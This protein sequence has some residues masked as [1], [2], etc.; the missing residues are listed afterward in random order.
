RPWG[1]P[2]TFRSPGACPPPKAS[3]EE[4]RRREERASTHAPHVRNHV[5][6]VAVGEDAEESRHR[7]APPAD[8]AEQ[9]LV[10]LRHALA[11]REA[12]Y[13]RHRADAGGAVAARTVHAIELAAFHHV[14]GARAL[15]RKREQQRER[16]ANHFSFLFFLRL[17]GLSSRIRASSRS[18]SLKSGAPKA[19][20]R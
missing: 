4:G 20:L 7:A 10:G 3:L 6:R 12:R 15:H 2:G 5:E 19:P 13:V 1:R 9:H 8:R 14:R 16:D 11:A 18:A 17:S